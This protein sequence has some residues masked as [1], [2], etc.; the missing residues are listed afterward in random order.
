MNKNMSVPDK[1]YSL[2]KMGSASTDQHRRQARWQMSLLRHKSPYRITLVPPSL[3]S[4]ITK[5]YKFDLGQ[6]RAHD[7]TYVML[8]KNY[9]VFTSLPLGKDS[10]YPVHCDSDMRQFLLW[11]RVHWHKVV[12]SKE[13]SIPFELAG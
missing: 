7:C 3:I 9:K 12:P 10:Q 8:E 5:Q 1:V 4:C 11:N 2:F 13:K 6:T